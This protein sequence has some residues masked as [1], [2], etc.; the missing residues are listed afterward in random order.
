MSL[1]MEEKRKR[2]REKKNTNQDE[3]FHYA[4]MLGWEGVEGGV[5]LTGM[6]NKKVWE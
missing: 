2:E 6:P 5:C 4:D 3:E 1:E